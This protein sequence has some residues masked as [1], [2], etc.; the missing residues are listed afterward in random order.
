MKTTTTTIFGFINEISIGDDGWAMICPFGDHPSEALL[1]VGNGKLKRQKAIQRITKASA[2]TMVAQFHNSRKGIRKFLRGVNIYVG[3]PDVPGLE[4]RYPDKQPKGVFADMQTRDDGIYGLPVFTN[5]G[6]EIVEQKKF[7]AFSGRL[8]NAVPDGEVNG[9]PAYCPTEIASVGLTNHPHLPVHFFNADDTLAEAPA[10][11]V[12]QNQKHTMKKKL[13][14]LCATL[15]IQFANET[16]DDAAT[17][18]ALDQVHAKVAAFANEQTKAAAET[19]TIR[20]KL[21]ALC[22]KLGITFANE[23]A[24]TDPAATIAQA[25]EKIGTLNTDLTNART[26]F[27]NERAARINDA[28]AVALTS[29][30]ITAA[31]KPTWENRLKVEAQFVNE[32]NALNALPTKVKTASVVTVQFRGKDT[33]V[34]LSDPGARRQ[35]VN[36]VVR[37]IAKETGLHPVKHYALIANLAAQRHPALFADVPHVQ[38]K[39]PGRAA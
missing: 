2:D 9:V 18:A 27:A 8:I 13:I 19:K 22:G 14:A 7:R 35:F 12:T 39:M 1:D 10:E 34:D 26:Q 3:H 33:Q 31:E 16:A 23:A 24:I 38:I 15:G 21:L 32:L 28:L 30:R 37:D 29:G 4:A 20:E 25:E 11:A 17:E 36:E 5:E 6:S